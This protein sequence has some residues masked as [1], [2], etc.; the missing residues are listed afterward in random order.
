[1]DLPTNAHMLVNV[2]GQV[3]AFVE[4]GE[5]IASQKTCQRMAQILRVMQNKVNGN[6]MQEVFSELSPEVQNG[7]S[8]LLQY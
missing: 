3:I 2:I 1:M 8:L 4:D 7:I 5:D 6:V